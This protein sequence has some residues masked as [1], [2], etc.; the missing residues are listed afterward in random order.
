MLLSSVVVFS[1]GPHVF[2]QDAASSES[3]AALFAGVRFLV[4]VGL[5]VTSQ[6]RPVNKSHAAVLKQR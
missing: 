5:D 1:M 4:S 3:F 2:L 6:V